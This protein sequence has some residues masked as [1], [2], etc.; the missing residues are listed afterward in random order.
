[1]FSK[2]KAIVLFVEDFKTCLQFYEEI[3]GLEVVVR[4]EQF[5]AFKM[6]GQDFAINQLQPA[7][8]MVNVPVDH[9]EAQTGGVDRVMMCA[10]V[11]DVDEAYETL[12]A[13]GVQFTKAPVNQDWGIRAAYFKDPEGNIWEIL[14]PLPA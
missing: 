11:E 1:M 13:K 14:K 8:E 12:K 6:D 2:V 4:E 7:S 5:A 3:L 9:F 10:E